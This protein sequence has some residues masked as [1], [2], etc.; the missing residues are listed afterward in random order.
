MHGDCGDIA[1]RIH[2]PD[3]AEQL[4]LGEH[5]VRV[6]RQEGQKV[7]LPGGKIL[8]HAVH[9]DAAGCLVDLQAADLDHGIFLYIAVHQALVAVQVRLHPGHQLAG[10]EGLR[11]VIVRSKAQPPDLVDIVLLGGNHDDRDVLLLPHLPADLEAV[12]ARKHQIQDHQLKILLQRALQSYFPVGSY[13]H[14]KTGKLQII[15][16]QIRNGFFVFY[17]QYLAHLTGT[18]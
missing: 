17:N 8:L 14:L 13:L 15:L 2:I 16:F 1:H 6:L 18:S 9:P 11:H 4:F 7:E 10:A 3:L 5:V 12:H